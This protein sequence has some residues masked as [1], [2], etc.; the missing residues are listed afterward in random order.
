MATNNYGTYIPTELPDFAKLTDGLIGKINTIGAT[1]QAEKDSL[2][3]MMNEANALMNQ[4]EIYSTQ[5]LQEFVLA[6]A[7]TGR[8]L[9]S[10]WNKDLKAGI[11]DPKEYKNRMNNIKD[12]WAMLANSAKTF[13]KTNQELQDRQAPGKDGKMPAGSEFEQYLSQMHA[14]I[15]DLKN[16]RA[17]FDP[18][19]GKPYTARITDQGIDQ[20]T[21]TPSVRFALPNNL[22]DNR[23]DVDA[24]VTSGT[25][26]MKDWK[27]ESGNETINSPLENKATTKAIISLQQGILSND[28][29]VSQVLA[30]YSANDY[31]YYKTDAER[32]S[33]VLAMADTDIRAR[34]LSGKPDYT[35]EELDKLY[36]DLDKKLIFVKPDNTGV[37]QPII[38]EDQR[39]EAEQIVLDKIYS[40]IGYEKTLD[41]PQYRGG[42]NNDKKVKETPTTPGKAYDAWVNKDADLL[43][44][45]SGNKYKF[46]WVEGG[47]GVIEDEK[48]APTKIFKSIYD[49]FDMFGYGS[50]N[51]REE[52]KRLIKNKASNKPSIQSATNANWLKSGWKQSEID[53]AV[54]LGKIK[55]IK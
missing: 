30:H 53:E 36:S 46:K 41:E 27:I 43:S 9:I 13:D 5:N 28:R 44:R 33:K 4:E 10:Q 42:G 21:M 54:K 20:S 45:L 31:D 34:K 14:E 52:W 26:G 55:V 38:T 50:A 35:K 12:G 3:N 51:Q 18:L 32:Q 25:A 47:L 40:N 24:L 48:K 16:K 1:R 19:T 6:G 15:G 49:M 2:D 17:F 29:Y 23:L 39:K 22:F 37:Y 8:S 11:L 7:E